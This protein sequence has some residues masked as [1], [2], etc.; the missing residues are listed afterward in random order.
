MTG[1]APVTTPTA[2]GLPKAVVQAAASLPV[3]ATGLPGTGSS[4]TIAPILVAAGLA[5]AAGSAIA[6]RRLRRGARA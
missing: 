2:T 4:R 6:I 1:G 5:L 3:A